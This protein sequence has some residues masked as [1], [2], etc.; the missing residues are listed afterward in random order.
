MNK[1]TITYAILLL[2]VFMISTNFSE[3]KYC[4]LSD[5]IFIPYNK[6]LQKQKNLYLTGSG[7]A[8][9]GDIQKINAHYTSFDLL[10]VEEARRL[11]VEVAEGYLHRYNQNEPIRPYLHNYPFAIGNF[12]ITISFK[13]EQYGRVNQ[14]YVALIFNTKDCKIYYGAYDHEKKKFID[15]YEEPYETARDIVLKGKQGS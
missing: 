6:E 10:N 14:N 2:L 12:E 4:K 13:D 8:M 7:G 9:M 1:K 5:R 15:L 11:F 3:P